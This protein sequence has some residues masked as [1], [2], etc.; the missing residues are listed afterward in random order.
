MVDS[1]DIHGYMSDWWLEDPK[2]P[3]STFPPWRRCTDLGCEAFLW[4]RQRDE[5]PRIGPA[6][7]DRGK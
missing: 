6:R 4:I 3:V 7:A 2:V 5:L 1:N